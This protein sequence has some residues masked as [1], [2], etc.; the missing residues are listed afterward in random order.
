MISIVLIVRRIPLILRARSHNRSSKEIIIKLDG[1][2][3]ENAQGNVNDDIGPYI[4][5]I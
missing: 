1:N 2:H 4:V 3:H 5:P